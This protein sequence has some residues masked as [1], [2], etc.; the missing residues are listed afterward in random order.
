MINTLFSFSIVSNPFKM[1]VFAMAVILLT[2]LGRVEIKKTF[3]LM[4]YKW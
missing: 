1:S 3:Y 4:G 2:K